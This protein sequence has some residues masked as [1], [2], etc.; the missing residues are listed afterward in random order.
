MKSRGYNLSLLQCCEYCLS[1][2]LFQKPFYLFPCSHG[3]HIDCML[4]LYLGENSTVLGAVGPANQYHPMANTMGDPLR[5]R[6]LSEHQIEA[7]QSSA[8]QLQAITARV[9]KEGKNCDKRVLQQLDSLQA[10]LDGLIS[11]DCPLC[12]D[13]MIQL[14]GINLTNC[15]SCVDSTRESSVWDL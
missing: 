10:K 11:C 3:Y 9:A 2:P 15:R 1:T 5:T 8:E 13:I 4:K 14:V 12:G 6:I 7:I